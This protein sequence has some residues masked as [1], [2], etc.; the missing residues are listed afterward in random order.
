MGL[1]SE[2]AVKEPVGHA[3]PVGGSFNL[4]IRNAPGGSRYWWA[5]YSMGMCYSGWLDISE[6]WNCP[7][8]AYGATDLEILVVDSDYNIKHTKSGLGP[9]YD[10]RTYIYDCSTEILSEEVPEPEFRGFGV[11]EYNKR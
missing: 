11:S 8:G 9:I 4:R 2:Y 5:S 1:D 10:D 3:S 6:T 7:Y